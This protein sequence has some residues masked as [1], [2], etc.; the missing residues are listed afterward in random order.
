M[1]AIDNIKTIRLKNGISQLDMAKALGI[2]QSNY[3]KLENGVTALTIDK[4]EQI[5]KIF[6]MDII[7]VL[8]YGE[9]PMRDS[10]IARRKMD[11]LSEENEILKSAFHDRIQ[12]IH[13]FRFQLSF[14]I[15][16][17]QLILILIKGLIKSSKLTKIIED[18]FHQVY[19]TE[20]VDKSIQFAQ[21][22]FSRKEMD[23]ELYND[24]VEY[25]NKKL[26]KLDLT[27]WLTEIE[28]KISYLENQ[29]IKKYEKE[30]STSKKFITD[31]PGDKVNF[32]Y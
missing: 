27:I 19:K 15:D 1:N 16:V 23:L 2:N 17:I 6:K 26:D 11:Q 30:L 24:Q 29:Y 7:E 12:I 4:L 32:N 31:V 9:E 10:L 8:A 21:Q 18:N 5:G 3:A 25:F 28:T 14:C 22:A 13:D 20:V